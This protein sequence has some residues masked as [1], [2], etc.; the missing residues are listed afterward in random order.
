MP[1]W[2]SFR[3][4]QNDTSIIHIHMVSEQDRAKS[5][6]RTL[7]TCIQLHSLH[8]IPITSAVEELIVGS[9]LL[10]NYVVNARMLSPSKH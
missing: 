5:A 8:K 7:S 3:L 1:S 6:L 4:I 9:G 10:V 2:Y